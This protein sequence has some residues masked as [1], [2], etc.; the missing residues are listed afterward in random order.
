MTSLLTDPALTEGLILSWRKK[1]G[2]SARSLARA[3]RD[4]GTRQ[5][6]CDAAQCMVQKQNK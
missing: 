1:S 3:A 6:S 5:Q 2:K 4:Y